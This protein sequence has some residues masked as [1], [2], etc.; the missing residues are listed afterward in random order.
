MTEGHESG[1][2]DPQ[3][4]P[5]SNSELRA[6]RVTKMLR[7]CAELVSMEV[8]DRHMEQGGPI[9]GL[10]QCENHIRQA[11]ERAKWVGVKR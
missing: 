9:E 2:M 10:R 11:L 7:E 5:P 3:Q 6:E 4:T 8:N 1:R